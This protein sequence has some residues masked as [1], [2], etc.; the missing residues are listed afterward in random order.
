[1]SKRIAIVQSSYIP[2]KGY[3][4]LIAS[5]D[6]FVLYDDAQYTKRDWRNRN[7]IKTPQGPLWLTIPVVVK[8]RFDQRVCDT[9]VSD[10]TW[11][12]KHWRSIRAHYSRAPCFTEVA[13]RLEELFLGSSSDRLSDINRRFLVALCGMLGITTRLTWSMDYNLE[14]GRTRKIAGICRQAGATEY[15]SGP[16]ARSYLDERQFADAGIAVTYADYSAYPEYTQLYPPFDHY[17]S[18]IDLLVHLGADAPQFMQSVSRGYERA[19]S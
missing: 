16:S 2:W 17:V 15:I 18:V 7:R 8:G 12:E 14:S 13:A 19:G 4:D 6:E 5:C 3:F 10:S 9:V 11:P 1:L